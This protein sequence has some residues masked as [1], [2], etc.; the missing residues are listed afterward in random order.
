MQLS[1][2]LAAVKIS[3]KRGWC[4][5]RTLAMVAHQSK[6]MVGIYGNIPLGS[7]SD[8]PCPR[9]MSV[10][11]T[12]CL[13]LNQ[14]KRFLMLAVRWGAWGRCL[15]DTIAVGKRNKIGL[16]S[17]QGRFLFVHMSHAC[18]VLWKQLLGVTSAAK[19][20]FTSPSGPEVP[21]KLEVTQKRWSNIKISVL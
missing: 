7:W 5:R 1:G 14:L 18:P 6:A 12:P 3:V 9:L 19:S 10:T 15:W 17:I 2:V 20:L 4:I 21:P 13:G 8:L 11:W 16:V